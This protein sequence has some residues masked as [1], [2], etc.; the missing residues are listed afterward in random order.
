M[1]NKVEIIETRLHAM[2]IQK[3]PEQGEAY[4]MEN[5]KLKDRIKELEEN[6]NH[7][8][9]LNNIECKIDIKP[10]KEKMNKLISLDHERNKRALNLIIFCLKEEEEDDPLSIIK[11]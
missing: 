3:T 8:L 2:E 7:N 5:I 10:I 1:E 4:T 11:T 9:T 6:V